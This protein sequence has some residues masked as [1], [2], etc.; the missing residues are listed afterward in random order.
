MG[1]RAVITTEQERK[2]VYLHWN[3][4]KDS[5]E[6][7]L[8]YCKEQEFRPPEQDCYGWAA[9]VTVISNFFGTGLSVGIDT[10]EKLDCD[11]YDNG[12]YIIKDWEIVGRKFHDGNEQREYDLKDMLQA[13]KASQPATSLDK[14]VYK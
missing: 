8:A 12:M 11:N 5:V 13:I 3:G 1:N 6:A 10:L 9:L 2:G 4:G 7:F 14:A